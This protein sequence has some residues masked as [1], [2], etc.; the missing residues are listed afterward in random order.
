MRWRTTSH[1]I[2]AHHTICVLWSCY[3]VVRLNLRSY[4]I[5]RPSY[6]RRT[7]SY[8]SHDHFTTLIY[9]AM[10]PSH[11]AMIVKPYVIVRLSFDCRTIYL[12]FSFPPGNH[13][14]VVCHRTTIIRLSYDVIRFHR[15]YRCVANPSFPVWPQ[16]YDCNIVADVIARCDQCFSKFEP[17]DIEVSIHLQPC[18]NI[19]KMCCRL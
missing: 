5:A 8:R 7:T 14:H 12:W 17:Y 9:K 2:E 4:D 13:S 19:Y 10:L 11:H 18:V 15:H 16:N 3:N 1:D 6:D